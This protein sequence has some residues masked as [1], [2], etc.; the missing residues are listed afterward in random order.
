MWPRLSERSQTDPSAM[1]ADKDKEKLFA[2]KL[3]S[4]TKSRAAYTIMTKIN[5]QFT[6]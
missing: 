4:E 5:K 1:S 6:V 2:Q 3:K